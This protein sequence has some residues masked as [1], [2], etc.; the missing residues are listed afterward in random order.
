MNPIQS[1]ILP[2]FREGTALP[3]NVSCWLV[4]T[5]KPATQD[6]DGHQTHSFEVTNPKG[7]KLLVDLYTKGNHQ[8][9]HGWE[10]TKANTTDQSGYFSTGGLRITNN[11][12]DDYDGVYSL[13]KC[14]CAVLRALGF[15]VE[16]INLGS[17]KLDGTP[18]D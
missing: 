1:P 13:P 15:K 8:T 6:K 7:G 4:T 3:V 12:L 16:D 5:G 14:V 11:E 2:L 9:P 17:S 18:N 10:A